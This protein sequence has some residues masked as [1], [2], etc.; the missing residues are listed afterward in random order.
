[1]F[2][3]FRHAASL[4]LIYGPVAEVSP[5]LALV[6]LS[7]DR[8]TLARYRWR[9]AAAD[10]R[11]FGFDL[12]EPLRHGQTFFQTETERYL[13]D[14]TPEPV[15]CIPLQSSSQGARLGW[16]IGNMHFTVEVRADAML[17]EDSATI[18]ALLTREGV[19]FSASHERFQPFHGA[20]GHRHT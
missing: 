12:K 7:V 14:Q 17:V 13:I 5:D 2:A 18:R 16:L 15:L 1:M 19:M 4:E 3:L 20:A 10:G 8:F 11:E 9:G 6:T